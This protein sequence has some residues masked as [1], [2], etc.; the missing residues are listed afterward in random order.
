[1]NCWYCLGIL[2]VLLLLCWMGSC[3]CGTALVH[4][5]VGFQLG[6]FLLVVMFDVLLLS[7]L[8]SRRCRSVDL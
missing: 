3:P 7:L 8:V 6:V 2:L 1:M 5:L 4:L